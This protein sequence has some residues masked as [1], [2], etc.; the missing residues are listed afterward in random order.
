MKNLLIIFFVTSVFASNEIVPMADHEFD[1]W[2]TYYYSHKLPER[3]KSALITSSKMGVFEKE[4]AIPPMVAFFSQIIKQCPDSI[5]TWL[6]FSNSFDKSE[7]KIIWEFFWYSQDSKALKALNDKV[8]SLTSSEK[9]SLKSILKRKYTPPLERQIEDASHLDV[10][11]GSFMATGEK[12]YVYKI[13]N[14]LS[15]K[16]LEN[17]LYKSVIV[18]SAIWSLRNN[19]NMHLPVYEACKK[20]LKESDGQKKELL[21]MVLDNVSKPKPHKDGWLQNGEKAASEPYMNAKKG[22]GCQLLITDDKDIFEKWNHPSDTFK[23]STTETAIRNKPIFAIIL[24]AD[25]GQDKN[26]NAD[27]IGDIKIYDPN[28][29]IYGETENAIIWDKKIL[30]KGLLGLSLANMG[31]KIEPD[32]PNGLYK[33][34]AKV[35]DRIKGVSLS[36]SNS[37]TVN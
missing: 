7:R 6:N 29:K 15:W 13:I 21:K 28:G 17:D 34:K 8:S 30:P 31:I 1:N 5:D 37:F 14:T 36:L 4:T 2:M 24:F 19:A 33:I 16:N 20:E 35:T 18:K 11:W 9:D 27:I 22:F 32:D 12:E 10:L 23:I 26:G 3:F 25:P